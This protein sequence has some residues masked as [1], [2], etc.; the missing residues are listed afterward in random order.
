MKTVYPFKNSG[1]FVRQ[2]SELSKSSQKLY[3]G[4]GGSHVVMSPHGIVYAVAGDYESANKA[5]NSLMAVGGA[6]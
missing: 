1:L 4:M 2:V 5:L 6:Q 3:G